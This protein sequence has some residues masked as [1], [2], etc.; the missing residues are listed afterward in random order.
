LSQA[1]AEESGRRFFRAQKW[2]STGLDTKI[3]FEYSIEIAPESAVLRLMSSQMMLRANI[4]CS[5]LKEKE[6]TF[7]EMKD[8][9][10]TT[11]PNCILSIA[12]NAAI[13]II[14]IAF[15]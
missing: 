9:E 6:H 4:K 14:S 1:G 13:D 3:I 8:S 10:R 2:Q 7:E 15:I 12:T 5:T 11:L